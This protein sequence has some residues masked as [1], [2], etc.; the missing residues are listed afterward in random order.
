MKSNSPSLRTYEWLLFFALSFLLIASLVVSKKTSYRALQKLH[1]QQVLFPKGNIQ[2][3]ITGCVKKPGIYEVPPGTTLR[4]L[5]RKAKPKALADLEALRVAQVLENS[6]AICIPALE[7]ISIEVC[8]AIRESKTLSLAAGSRL[9]DLKDKIALAQDADISIFKRRRLLKNHEKIF[10]P[11]LSPK[12]GQ[13]S[14]FQV[15]GR[16]K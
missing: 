6:C 12:S 2:V 3:E 14:D 1:K 5:L 10:I 9:S 7:K 11:H 15:V 8:G 13:E 4:T 16:G